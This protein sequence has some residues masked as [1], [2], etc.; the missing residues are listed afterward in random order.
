MLSASEAFKVGCLQRWA[1]EGLSPEDMLKRAS[2]AI[3]L[4]KSALIGELAGKAIDVGQNAVNMAVGYGLPLAIAAPPIAGGIAGYGLARA[5]DIDDTDINEIKDREVVDSLKHNTNRL[6][7]QRAVRDY[8][9]LRQ[10]TGRYF[11]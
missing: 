3:V 1:Q 11:P 6:N 2:D 9:K 8:Q 4:V 10:S 5:T 7:R